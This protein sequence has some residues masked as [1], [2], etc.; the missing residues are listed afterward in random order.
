MI[1]VVP[2]HPFPTENA[3]AA[4]SVLKESAEGWIGGLEAD[5]TGLGEALDTTLMVAKV[6]CLT[7]PRGAIF[8]TWDAWVNAMQVGSAVFAAAT[9]AEDRVRCRIAHEDRTLQATGPQQYVTPGTWLTAFHLAVV[10]RERDRIT[11]LCRVP[12]S[13]LRDNNAHFDAFEYAWVDALQTY[14]LGGDGLS[15]K[16]VAAID[17]TDPAVATHPE[18]AGKLMYPPMEMFHRVVRGDHA[19]FD[20]ALTAALERHKEYWTDEGRAARISGLV[21]LAPL[22]MACFARSEGIPVE[23]ESAYLPATLL[24][25]NWCGEFPT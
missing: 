13:L 7:D 23:V 20:R 9:T 15:A 19:G 5:S 17:G 25:G 1:A 3:E 18:A 4:L 2:R 11:A 24:A 12:L 6:H 21:A 16:L 10:C 22:A 8:P 14:W